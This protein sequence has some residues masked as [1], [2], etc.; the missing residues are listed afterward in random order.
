MN[1]HRVTATALAGIAAIFLLIWSRAGGVEVDLAVLSG[2]ALLTA[3]IALPRRRWGTLPG[4]LYAFVLVF[5]SPFFQPFT[6][7]HLTHPRELGLFAG[8]VLL[9]ALG[10]VATAAG[11][12]A[13]AGRR[14]P[15]A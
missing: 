4:A 10:L 11:L 15:S 7:Y 6:V 8:T 1:L 14:E 13:V 5:V 2:C 12:A 3:A 9:Q